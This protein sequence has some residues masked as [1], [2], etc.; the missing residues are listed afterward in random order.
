MLE[1]VLD[2]SYLKYRRICD[3]QR[4]S[5]MHTYRSPPPTPRASSSSSADGKAPSSD[6]ERQ[7]LLDTRRNSIRMCRCSSLVASRNRRG[8]WQLIDSFNCPL[9]LST[10]HV[11]AARQHREAHL[12]L[13]AEVIL[14]LHFGFTNPLEDNTSE[15]SPT[16]CAS[17]TRSSQSE[18]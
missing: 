13:K 16:V 8:A 5:R 12:A 11:K 4:N 17:R 2:P 15:V 7:E 10:V 18:T 6:A 3:C 1:K 14:K 9:I